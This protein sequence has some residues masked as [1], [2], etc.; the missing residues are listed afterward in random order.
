[1]NVSDPLA[2]SGAAIAPAQG[3]EPSSGPWTRHGLNSGVIFGATYRGVS[4]FP[5]TLS[6]ALGHAGSWLSWRLMK[7]T[8]AA[9]VDNLRALFPSEST[10]QLNGRALGVFRA[11]ARD[12]IDFLR[13]LQAT[14]EQVQLLFDFKPE[15]ARLFGELLANHRGI[16]LVSG[17]YG[18]WEVG[19]V[20][21]RRIVGLPLT[22]MTLA[23]A[24]EEV[25]RLR[26]IMR[27]RLGVDTIEVRKSLD[28]ALQIRRRLSDNHVVA[29]LMD[30]H[31]G[32]DRVQVRLLGRCAWFL[33][34]PA[35][36]G[37][38]TGAPLVPCFIERTGAG[39]FKVRAG[40]PIHVATDAPREEAI[41]RAAQQFAGQLETRLRANPQ[42]WYHFYSYWDAQRDSDDPHT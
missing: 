39:R 26:R 28:T 12:V 5:R 14:D 40:D 10:A 38:L 16:I 20:F 29:M 25:H 4:R 23:E 24:S 31:I 6:Y 35:L 7:R 11:Y 30:R 33:K 2:D 37:Y 1:L 3:R 21:M 32:R 19:S 17:H 22:I 27:E 8:R 36:M 9:V 41:Q 13:A 18:N 15:D 34:T 42:Y